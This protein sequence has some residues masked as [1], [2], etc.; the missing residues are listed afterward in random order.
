MNLAMVRCLHGIFPLPLLVMEKHSLSAIVLL[1]VMPPMQQELYSTVYTAGTAGT[2]SGDAKPGSI[3]SG[4][5]IS[6]SGTT[7]GAGTSVTA[8]FVSK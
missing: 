6:V 5:G 7:Q 1:L 3:D 2:Y 8:Q 4:H